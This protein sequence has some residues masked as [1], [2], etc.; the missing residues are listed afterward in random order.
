MVDDLKQHF[1]KIDFEQIPREQNRA[2]DAMATI[3]SLI[4][5]PP[6]ETRYEFL[7]DNLLVPSYEIMPIETIC[8]VGPESQLYGSIFTYLR[9]NTLPPNLSNNQHHTFIRQSS[10]Y[11]ILVDILYQ[12]GLDGTLLRCLE[13]DEAQIAL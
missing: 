5:L 1:T 9:D 10:R 3:V 11:V 6:N 2:V 7:V 4:D 12:R 13:S 8:V